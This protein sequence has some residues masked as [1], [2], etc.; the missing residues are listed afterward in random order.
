[1]RDGV[2]RANGIWTLSERK[3]TY[4]AEATFFRRFVILLD[5]VANFFRAD[6]LSF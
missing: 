5:N 6:V 3:V 4:F 2:K 1:V